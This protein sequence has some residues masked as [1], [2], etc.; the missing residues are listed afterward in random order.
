MNCFRFLSRHASLL[1]IWTTWSSK[2][3][4][5]SLCRF[6]WGNAS[7]WRWNCVVLYPSAAFCVLNHVMFMRKVSWLMLCR[8]IAVRSENHVKH[9]ETV[10][11]QSLN[12]E[13]CGKYSYHS[14]EKGY[15]ECVL[16]HSHVL[17]T[18]EDAQWCPAV[19]SAMDQLVVESM[20]QWEQTTAILI[21]NQRSASLTSPRLFLSS[22]S[23]LFL[24]LL[25]RRKERTLQPAC[26]NFARISLSIEKWV[27]WKLCLVSCFCLFRPEGP[28]STDRRTWPFTTDKKPNDL[29]KKQSAPATPTSREAKFQLCRLLR[30]EGP[31][32]RKLSHFINGDVPRC[33]EYLMNFR[34]E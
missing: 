10:C 29:N 5:C 28:R 7:C 33:P 16:P 30:Q 21:C 6:Y 9:M 19:G 3:R 24:S 1:E 17:G 2:C 26:E 23:V 22:V 25:C 20:T 18:C 14:A 31:D 12:F 4:V 34:N 8:E 15:G 32:L 13:A 27:E 11:G